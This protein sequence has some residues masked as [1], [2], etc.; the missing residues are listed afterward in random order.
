[1]RSKM[2]L[3]STIAAPAALSLALFMSAATAAATASDD[4]L[5]KRLAMVHTLLF[6]SSAAKRIEKI[7]VPHHRRDATLARE[8]SRVPRLW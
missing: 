2:K 8:N 6:D 4:P 7:H 1:M 3:L 5:A